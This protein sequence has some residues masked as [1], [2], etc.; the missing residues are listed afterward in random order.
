MSLVDAVRA[1]QAEAGRRYLAGEV[2]GSLLGPEDAGPE[3]ERGPRKAGRPKGATNKRARQV[4]ELVVG[5]HGCPVEFLASVY[6]RPLAVLAAELGCDLVEALKCQIK[7][8]SDVAPYLRQKLPM[9]VE[10]DTRAAMVLQLAVS[11]QMAEQILGD[12]A[13]EGSPLAALL[14][15]QN[16]EVI[17]AAVEQSNGGKSNGSGQ[18]VDLDG[19][20]GADPL[21][22]DQS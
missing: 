12:G 2:Q 19:Q 6:D 13:P 20:S 16:Q 8:A 1:R 14:S 10:V 5:K 11:P 21:I 17:E 4:A 9:A 3:E 22:G 18:G 7:A 15:E